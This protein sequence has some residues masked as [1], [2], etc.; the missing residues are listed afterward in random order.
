MCYVAEDEPAMYHV[1]SWY[2][3][4][5]VR[6]DWYLYAAK[7]LPPATAKAIEHNLQ[8]RGS[9]QCLRRVLGRWMSVTPSANCSWCMV[10]E[11]LTKM[12]ETETVERIFKEC[13]RDSSQ[14]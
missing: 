2:K 12:N 14:K 4:S 11:A 9:E 1:I 13:R 8:G 5:I 10:V 3:S 7:L 6:T